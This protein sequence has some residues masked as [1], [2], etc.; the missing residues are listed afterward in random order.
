MI[1]VAV[2]GAEGRMGQLLT[3]LVDQAADTELVGLITEPGRVPHI[4]M[5]NLVC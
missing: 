2:H 1:P 5:R 4:A 3:T